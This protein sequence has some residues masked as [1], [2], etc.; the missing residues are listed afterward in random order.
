MS[1]T[2]GSFQ[3]LASKKPYFF[4]SSIVASPPSS[5]SA[6]SS[7]PAPAPSPP[8]SSVAVIK[9]LASDDEGEEKE[10]EKEKEEEVEEE[11]EEEKDNDE[12]EEERE[13][14][15]SAMCGLTDFQSLRKL[16]VKRLSK[17][18]YFGLSP[19]ENEQV[20]GEELQKSYGEWKKREG[21]LLD[22]VLLNLVRDSC[23][24]VGTCVP[25]LQFLRTFM[26]SRVLQQCAIP[27]YSSF[28]SLTCGWKVKKE[29]VNSLSQTLSSPMK[30]AR[31]ASCAVLSDYL[32]ERILSVEDDGDAIINSIQSFCSRLKDVLS[33]SSS[34]SPSSFHAYLLAWKVV[35]SIPR[36]AQTNAEKKRGS[37]EKGGGGKEKDLVRNLRNC[38]ESFLGSSKGLV[39]E[40]LQLLSV[41]AHTLLS[42]DD[43]P[44][45]TSP[46]S[47]SLSSSVV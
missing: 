17:F 33:F 15:F 46:S 31:D 11:K 28:G 41:C 7:A 44:F 22:S 4:F 39:N 8:E 6:S 14:V 37:G 9:D 10:E 5:S 18:L 34:L 19:E 30:S 42:P 20:E 43:D 16:L 36:I 40:F 21:L 26:A 12:E 47:L 2:W 24:D 35:V 25:L 13:L 27:I 45:S 32:K 23:V 1:Q 29:S 38:V 3:L